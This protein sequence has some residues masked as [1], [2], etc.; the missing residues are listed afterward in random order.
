MHTELHI[1][2]Y[3]YIHWNL[4][5]RDT[6]G[7]WAMSLVERSSL[8]WRFV[9]FFYCITLIQVCFQYIMNYLQSGLVM[10]TVSPDSIYS[11]V[12]TPGPIR[13]QALVNF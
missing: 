10:I 2:Q 8:S 11:G 5:E 9:F 6:L 4:R 7:K 12:A 13:A 3:I 1:Y